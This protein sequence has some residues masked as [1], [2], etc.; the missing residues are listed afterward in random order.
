MGRSVGGINQRSERIG[1][2]NKSLIPSDGYDWE[3]HLQG[4]SV[5]YCLHI[6]VLWQG[7]VLVA[8]KFMVLYVKQCFPAP[9][10]RGGARGRLVL[11]HRT[12]ALSGSWSDPA[13]KVKG[14]RSRYR[15]DAQ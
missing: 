12:G 6:H 1:L 7:A 14:C 2:E 3:A 15:G 4:P 13:R 9:A 5:H 8:L 11:L 10:Q